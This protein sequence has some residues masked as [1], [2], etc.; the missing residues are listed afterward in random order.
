MAA[1][2]K[3]ET[4]NEEKQAETVNE[5]KQEE[6]RMTPAEEKA[7]WMEKVPFRAFK[8]SGKYSSDIHV[9]LNGK[10]Y[11]IK[12][13]EEVM[14][15][16]SVKQIIVRSMDQDQRTAEMIEQLSNDFKNESRKYG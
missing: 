6:K 10:V 15:P 1:K 14:I 5:E 7:Y 13:G 2:T 4:V 8:D 3:A 9:G 11:R 16:R 12:R